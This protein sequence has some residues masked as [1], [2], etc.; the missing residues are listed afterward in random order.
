MGKKIALLVGISD[1]QNFPKLPPCEEDLSLM[2]ELIHNTGK[3]DEVVLLDGSPK[4]NRAKEE[5]SS[6]I[7]TYQDQELDEFFFYYTGHGIRHLEDFLFLFADFNMSKIEQTSLSNSELDS[8]LKSLNPELAVKVVDACQSGTEYIKSNQGLEVIFEKSS[9]ESFKKTYFLFSSSEV[10][11]SFALE[12]YSVFTKSFAKSLVN[13]A[14]SSIRYRDIMAYISD[15]YNVGKHQTPLFIQQA[16]NTEIFCELNADLRNVLAAKLGFDG[17][18]IDPEKDGTHTDTDLQK[19]ADILIANIKAKSKEYC[20]EEEAKTSLISLIESS[21]N[22]DWNYLIDEL[23]EVKVDEKQDYSCIQDMNSI[24]KWLSDSD[25]SYFADITFIKEEYEDK[26][27]IEIEEH[28]LAAFSAFPRKRTEY[29]L[30]TKYRDVINSIRQTA[31][32]PCCALVISFSPKEEVLP[33]FKAFVVYIFSKSKLTLF[34]KHEMEKEISWKESIVL[35]KNQWKIV[36]CSL[37]KI[38]EVAATVKIIL[39][40]IQESI[41][42]DFSKD[43][44]KDLRIEN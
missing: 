19:D 11:S 25:E 36:H 40:S 14:G 37:K 21:K 33:K 28:P 15:D 26:E 30:V 2:S 7:R 42:K 20:N 10:E 12:D 23:Y 22:F 6:F 34:Y 32:A 29:K 27:K 35:N 16:N 13:Y 3:Y 5:I 43:F 17:Q 31:P 41:I 18:V 39:E 8:M 9:N 4:S 24:A 38:D 44:G 1:Y